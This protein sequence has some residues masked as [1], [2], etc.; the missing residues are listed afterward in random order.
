M[1]RLKDFPWWPTV[2]VSETGAFDAPAEINT[3]GVLKNVWP[4]ASRGLK[5]IVDY[6]GHVFTGTI[7]WPPTASEDSL[8]WL[9]HILLQHWGEPMCVVE[10]IAIHFRGRV[11]VKK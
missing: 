5:L 11:P 1:S 8:I 2:W 10:N 6:R 4:V 7:K 3:V 9:R